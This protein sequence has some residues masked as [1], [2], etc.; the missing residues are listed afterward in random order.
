[1]DGAPKEIDARQFAAQLVEQ[2]RAEGIDV[3]GPGERL[4]ALTRT[5]L[6]TALDADMSEHPGSDKHDPAGRNGGNSRNGTRAKTV[7]TESVRWRLG[8]P[9][10]VTARSTPSSCASGN[11]G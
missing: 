1:M 5:V 7:L 3:V 8:C 9:G 11:A 4:T 2:V 6:E 10:T